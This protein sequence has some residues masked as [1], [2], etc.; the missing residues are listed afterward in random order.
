MD[1]AGLHRFLLDSDVSVTGDLTVE[2]ISGGRSNL[3]YRV[4]DEA[5]RCW[6]ARRPPTSGLTPS[7]HDVAREW[8]VGAALAG[9]GVPVARTVAFDR[10][11]R[12]VGAPLTVV[13]YVDGRVLRTAGDL[14]RLTDS[15]LTANALALVQTL[16][17]LHTID[18]AG[19]G[20]GDFGRPEGFTSRQV[21]TWS[22]QWELVKTRE[23]ADVERL[24]RRLAEAVPERT[25]AAIVHGDYR[26]D[27]TLVA[28]TD[29][30]RIL[31]VVDWELATL[32]DPLTDIALMCVYRQ[33][34]F[35]AVIGFEAAW[36]SP[37]Y[38]S[39]EELA[40]WYVDAT[41]HDLTDWN[42]YIALAYFKLG[43]IGEGIAHRARAGS[44]TGHAGAA[45]AT[46]EF[47]ARGLRALSGQ[48]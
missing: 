40:A 18:P 42:F 15:E 7:A 33:P 30:S 26:V 10:A 3:T 16:A 45:E 8:A 9:T 24:R 6:V 12:A 23:L 5:G 20:L 27:N 35:D 29:A 46:A 32:G 2:L 4:S 37:R 25:R 21:A 22:R 44:G 36:T 47:M 19:V 48:S 31:A 38:P 11:G 28:H 41:G 13:D 14:N 1:I 39:A 34:S 17:R 43:V